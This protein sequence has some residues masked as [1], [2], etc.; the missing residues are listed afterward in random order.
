MMA[1]IWR[2]SP[3]QDCT[4]GD[5]K[6]NQQIRTNQRTTRLTRVDEDPFAHDGQIDISDDDLPF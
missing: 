5:N 6:Q 2:T 3:E 4:I 1:A